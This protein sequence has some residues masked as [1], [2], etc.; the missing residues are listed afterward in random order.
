MNKILDFCKSNKYALIWTFFYVLVMWAVLLGMF[1]FNIFSTENW[2]RLAHAELHG[3]AGFVFG[4]MILAA[5]PLYVATTAIII[6]TKAPLFKIPVP[7]FLAKLYPA[8][9][10]PETNET[11]PPAPDDADAAA[12]TAPPLPTGLPAELRDA[13]IRARQHIGIA[14]KSAFDLSRMSDNTP[15]ATTIQPELQP[16]AQPE[17]QSDAALPLPTDFN[18]DDDATFA[19]TD[20]PVFTEINFDAPSSP[21]VESPI[22]PNDTLT[23]P[24]TNNTAAPASASNIA[25]EEYLKSHG[26]EITAIEKDIIITKDFAIA[27]HDDPDFWIADL[28][29]WFAAGKQKSSPAAAVMATAG[30]HGVRPILYLAQANIMDLDA[31]KAQWESQGITVITDLSQLPE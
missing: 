3:F 5:I 2:I 9:P 19:T 1:N 24:D 17:F 16:V 7:K 25:V 29:D 28:E 23:T 11:E 31:R 4:I 21:V 15:A 13:Y 8:P 22:A 14:Q 12:P 30:A 27:T 6:R 26:Y 10:P 20:A 18:F